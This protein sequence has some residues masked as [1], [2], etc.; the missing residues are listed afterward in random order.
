MKIFAKKRKLQLK[1]SVVGETME[2]RK[3]KK[4]PVWIKKETYGM[5]F[6]REDGRG[7]CGGG[8]PCMAVFRNTVFTMKVLR[9]YWKI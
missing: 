3:T 6:M 9:N 7:R 8:K 2:G 5:S 1:Y 4:H